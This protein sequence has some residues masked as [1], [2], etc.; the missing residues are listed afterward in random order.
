MKVHWPRPIFAV[1]FCGVLV[2]LNVSAQTSPPLGKTVVVDVPRDAW[3]IRRSQTLTVLRTLANDKA[4]KSERDVA[5]KN[6]DAIL[7]QFEKSPVSITP[8]EAMDLLQAFYVPRESGK[9]ELLLRMI[10]VQATLGWYDALRFGDESGR[11]EIVNNEAFFSRALMLRKDA[12]IRFIETEPA[13]AATAVE[14]GIQLARKLQN[15]GVQY[16]AHWP[17]SYGLLRMQ[18]GLQGAKIC[19]KPNEMPSKDW[20]AAFDKSAERITTYYRINKK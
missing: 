8:M 17:A 2:S 15:I 16:D 9:M 20:P 3:Q 1:F 18:C 5:A 10:A 14:Q 7:T 4:S 11:A 13:K 12:F 6:L 19:P